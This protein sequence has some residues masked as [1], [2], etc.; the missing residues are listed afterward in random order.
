MSTATVRTRTMTT[1]VGTLTVAA[2]DRGVRAVLW[3]TDT[4]TR[5]NIG[6]IDD[7]S[8]DRAAD[9]VLDNAVAQLSEY[10]ASERHQFDVPLDLV[11]T[12]FQ[13]RV[14]ESLRLVD[15]GTTASYSE[16]A[17]ALGQPSAVRAVAAANGRNPVSILLPC[18]RIIGSNG[19]LT[20]FAGGL[21]AKR[22]LLDHEAGVTTLL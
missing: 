12:E 19:S 13:K 22:W 15:Y 14:W 8:D 3:E 10:F 21:D 17:S 4:A 11:G 9:S 1:P 16:Q 6:D 7:G 2:S 20:G 18:H 5:V